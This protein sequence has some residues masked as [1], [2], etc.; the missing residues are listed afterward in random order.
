M[1]FHGIPPNLN[2][3]TK[4]DDGADDADDADDDGDDGFH[5]L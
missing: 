2:F 1:T 3:K 5:I 4:C